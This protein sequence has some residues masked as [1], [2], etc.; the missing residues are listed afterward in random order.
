MKVSVV[1]I[2]NLIIAILAINLSVISL[3]RSYMSGRPYIN[4][5]DMFFEPSDFSCYSLEKEKGHKKLTESHKAIIRKTLG[6]IC[7]VNIDGKNYLIV[8][9]ITGDFDFKDIRLVLAPY[10]YEYKNTGDFVS[11]IQLVKGVF[12]LINKDAF[13]KSINCKITPEGMDDERIN[14]QVAYV[15]KEG[16]DTSVIY[17]RLLNENKRFS[18]KNDI[19]KAKRIINFEKEEFVLECKNQCHLVR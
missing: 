8:N 10:Q 5:V 4:L 15:C 3:Y 11:E 18:Y 19:K 1:D 6:K 12:K 14:I 17:N 9:M 7:S 2:L 16:Y 13:E